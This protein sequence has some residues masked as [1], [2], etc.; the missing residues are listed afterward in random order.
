[1]FAPTYPQITTEK[2]FVAYLYITGLIKGKT[3]L[4]IF[5]FFGPR[6]Y[7]HWVCNKISKAGILLPTV[8]AF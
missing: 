8:A 1:M 5:F 2:L 3:Q 7:E 6:F 4:L